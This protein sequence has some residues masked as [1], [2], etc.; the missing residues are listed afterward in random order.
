MW[1]SQHIL[2]LALFF[3]KADK[4]VKKSNAKLSAVLLEAFAT[5]HQNIFIQ[6]SSRIIE[7][8]SVSYVKYVRK[9]L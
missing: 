3:K 7:C 9:Y 2:K 5:A 6:I 4:V 8:L 1:L